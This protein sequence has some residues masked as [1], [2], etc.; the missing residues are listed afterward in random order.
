MSK[1]R[2]YIGGRLNGLA[3][4]YIK[5]IHNMVLCAELVRKLGCAVFIPGIDFLC[6]V[7]LGTWEYKDYFDNSQPFL[8][9]CDAIFVTPNWETSE[10][11]KREI[12]RAKSQNIQVFYTIGELEQWLKG[13]K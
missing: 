1:K 2:I 7:I 10:G 13:M 11:T 9:C 12:E 3:C 5:N 6:G 8:D 4:D